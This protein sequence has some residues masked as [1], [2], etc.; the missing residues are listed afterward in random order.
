MY[1][2]KRW[3]ILSIVSSAL[4]LITMDTTIL[5]TALP[6]LTYDL[7][8]SASEK[9][10]IING[11]SLVMAGLIPAM[12][13]LGDRYGHKKIFSY[14]LVVF[15]AASLLAAFAPTPYVLVIA[16]V[17]LAVGASMMM[18]A[19]LSI[20]RITF[21]DPR[22]LGLA[23]GVWAA[24]ASG[25]AGLGPIVGGL[26][27]EHYWWGAAFL[28]NVPIALLALGLTVTIV[29][30]HEG[31]KDTKWDLIS[32]VQ[33]MIAMVA[34]VFAI[35]EF[36]KR[37][38]S[39]ALATVSAV[40]GVIGMIIFI[41][42][43]RR[44]LNPL[45]D[46]SLFK[47]SLFTAGCITAVVGLFGQLG[48]QYVV[49]QRLQL[50]EGMSPLQAGFI[51]VS[52][53]AAALI[54]GPI[55]GKMMH[56]YNVIHIKSLSLLLAALGTF[57]YILQFDAGVLGQIIGLALMGIGLG[58][59]MTAASHSIMSSAPPEKAGMAASI[60]EVAYEVGGAS[61]IAIVGS[62]SGLIYSLSMAVPQGLNVPGNVKDSLDEALIAA[63]G[64]PAQASEALK[65]AGRSAFDTSVFF[66]LIGLSVF[67][68][69]SALV[70]ARVGARSKAK[71]AA[72]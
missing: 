14:G 30:N 42:R 59:S 49:T 31:N 9:L 4:L 23:I 60:E 8:A 67:F 54:A 1:N 27:V 26:L 2:Y 16:R 65:E 38:G 17:L 53:P 36:A 61:G 5:Y 28:V 52:V 72:N 58:A 24:I 13:T 12:G 57:I 11:Y 40:I 63:E 10:W 51:T 50:V 48:V 66:V 62:L 25:G 19:T 56:R 15:T 29:P 35:K 45:I 70:V 33:I 55:A 21:T 32:S 71:A 69:L 64:L 20:I 6:S 46:L 3:F 34:I 41:R 39:P 22:E 47:I 68:A 37:E 44:S 7:G 43:Q 18:P